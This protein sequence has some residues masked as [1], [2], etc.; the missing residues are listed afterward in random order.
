MLSGSLPRCWKGLQALEALGL[1]NNQL[2]GH[3]PTSMCSLQQLS[4]LVLRGNN[5][6]GI[7]PKCLANM[8]LD[9]LDVG[10]N[11]IAGAI[12]SWI[13]QIPF[14]SV[15]SL[16]SNALNG[17]IPIGICQF[18]C[19]QILNLADNG[20][21]GTIPPCLDNITALTS[22]NYHG[23][24]DSYFGTEVNTKSLTQLYTSTARYLHS[25]DLSNNKFVGELPRGLTR[26]YK[27]QN[28]NLSRNNFSGR[29]PS[30]IADLWNLE[31]LDL[32]LNRFSGFTAGFLGFCGSLLF[33]R[34]W[35]QSFFLWLDRIIDPLLVMME[36]NLVRLQRAFKQHDQNT[37]W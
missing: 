28:L 11:K 34:S 30:E 21:S 32:S 26:L 13:A 19:L 5:F 27:L 31:S 1:E 33:K 25:I 8:S 22:P 14:L 35:R 3:I 16:E 17:E 4:V 18:C 36:A 37:I 15:L 20:L 10:H 23:N 7:L 2:E 29:I 24:W 6:R 9:V 12:P